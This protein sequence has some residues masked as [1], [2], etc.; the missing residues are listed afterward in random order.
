MTKMAD[1]IRLRT[2]PCNVCKKTLALSIQKENLT[3]DITGLDL[4][5]DLHGLENDPSHIRILYIDEK[6]FVRSINTISKFT[7]LLREE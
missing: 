4:F 7:T 5:V 3:P 1:T 2:E 6:G